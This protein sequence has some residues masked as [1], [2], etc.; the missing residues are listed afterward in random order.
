MSGDGRRGVQTKKRK[1]PPGSHVVSRHEAPSILHRNPSSP[2][3]N[4]M[5]TGFHYENVTDMAHAQQYPWRSPQ[6][7]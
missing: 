5:F 4:S 7:C 1:W 2:K 3:W 6:E